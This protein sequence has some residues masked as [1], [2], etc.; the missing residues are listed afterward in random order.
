[1]LGCFSKFSSVEQLLTIFQ[2]DQWNESE[3]FCIYQFV[4]EYDHTFRAR[5]FL[6]V[7][8]VEGP[9]STGDYWSKVREYSDWKHSE[10]NVNEITFP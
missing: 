8:V 7:E 5:F 4:R 1:M 10:R 6:R 2:P 9:P 3:M